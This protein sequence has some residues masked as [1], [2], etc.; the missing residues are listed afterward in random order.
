MVPA[1]TQ[2]EYDDIQ[3]EEM[4]EMHSHDMNGRDALTG[5]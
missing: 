5:Y 2:A 3:Y 1:S 4:F